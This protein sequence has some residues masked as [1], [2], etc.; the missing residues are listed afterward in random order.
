MNEL[1]N[2]KYEGYVWLSNEPNPKI[3]KDETFDFSKY[4]DG[5]NPFIVE[6]L[7][8]SGNKSIHIRHTDKYHIDQFDLDNLPDGAKIEDTVDEQYLPH[9]LDGVKKVNFKQLWVAE[10]D[11]NC[12]GMSVLK[13]KALI[14]TGFDINQ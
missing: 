1:N 9:S 5:S 10:P 12:E 7:L 6:A 3:L 13:M 2:I 14:F 4:V 11:E 8:K